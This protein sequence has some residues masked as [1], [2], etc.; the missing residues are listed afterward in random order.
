MSYDEIPSFDDSQETLQEG[1][2][3]EKAPDDG[4]KRKRELLREARQIMKDRNYDT[5]VVDDVLVQ[6]DGVFEGN[7]PAEEELRRQYNEIAEKN[8]RRCQDRERNTEQKRI[9][10]SKAQEL[11]NSEDWKGTAAQMKELMN[12]WKEIGNAGP[13]ND[14]LW[15]EFQGAR[16][17][18]FDR[19]RR[20]YEEADLLRKQ[21]KSKKQEI[22]AQARS[23]AFSS[24]DWK[25]THEVLEEML[26]RWKQAGSAG[27]E[28]DSLW[29]EFQSIRN[30]FYA[31]RKE[32]MQKRESEFLER[33]E[34]KSAL[35]TDAQA[36]AKACDYSAPAAERMRGMSEEWKSIGFCGNEYEDRLWSQ[37]RMA[38]DTY[39]QEKKAAGERKHREWMTKTQA[40]VD[41]RRERIGNIHRNIENLRER[42]NTIGNIDK[43]NQI[44]GWISE[45]EAQIRELE[46]EICRMEQELAKN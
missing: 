24:T 15:S 34:R 8:K 5:S 31:R 22:I 32:A 37:F 17:T 12:A 41:R 42:L 23:A 16:Q 9:L 36:Y 18:F 33:R 38:Q 11:Q 30:D 45:N 13:V 44:Y 6:F 46:E 35:V 28:D 25:G 10:I 14:L 40:A 4:I 20:H 26:S 39:W 2:Y 1:G 7:T 29:S 21:S 43:Q 27:R 3:Q 19:Q